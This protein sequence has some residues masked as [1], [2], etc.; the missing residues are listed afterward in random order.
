[1]GLSSKPLLS[2]Y[3]VRCG[4]LR[5]FGEGRDSLTEVPELIE[6][7]SWTPRPMTSKYQVYTSM[8]VQGYQSDVIYPTD[9]RQ[10]LSS[11][12][13]DVSVSCKPVYQVYDVSY[14]PMH[15]CVSY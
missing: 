1:M 4:A 8:R 5:R 7:I 14:R 2:R 12:R 9:E 11:R 10:P 13:A 3:S 6:H 15:R